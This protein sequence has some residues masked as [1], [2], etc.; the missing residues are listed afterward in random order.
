LP[1]PAGE[2]F[3]PIGAVDLSAETE[4]TITVTNRETNGFVILDAFQLIP[5]KP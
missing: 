1:L 2:L 5:A 4:A 3:R